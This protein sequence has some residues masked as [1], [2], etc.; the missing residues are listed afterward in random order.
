MDK[1]DERM[2]A[3][4]DRDPRIP[5]S[6]LAR[7]LRISQQVAD[8]RLKRLF[9]E[10]RITKLA[11][12]VNLK[13]LR[14]EHYR[15]FFKFH[16]KKGF[17]DKEMFDY[18]RKRKGVYW[19]ARIGGKYD[20]LVVLFVKDFEEFDSF[21]DEFNTTFP[22]VVKDYKSCYVLNH[23]LYRHKHLGKDLT[24][25]SYGYN[26]APVEIDELD[27]HILLKMRDDCRVSALE[28]SKG[29][30]V[31]YKTIINRIHSLEQKKVI[32]GYRMF[33]RSEEKLPFI[34]LLSFKDYSRSAEKTLLSYLA[35]NDS[36]TQTV[37]LFGIWDLF[38]HI[39][40]EDNE[41]L[42]EL[43]IEL[44]DRFS[45][46]DDYEIIPVFEDISINLMP[47]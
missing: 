15:I 17:S 42:Q 33:I 45:I 3:E 8:Y 12:I 28:L 43:L 27:R 25:I 35:A 24:A 14:Q 6:T 22:G 9:K 38:L 30:D 1:I 31:T 18:L 19:A 21:I 2:L 7:N 20:L 4:L 40:I 26:D 32:L 36:V 13:A 41:K 39:R 16:P 37:K 44:R 10:G 5:V 47:V 34:V 29:K 46:I 23:W 11:A